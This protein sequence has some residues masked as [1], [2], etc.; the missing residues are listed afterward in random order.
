VPRTR[1]RPT[2]K[3]KMKDEE[4]TKMAREMLEEYPIGLRLTLL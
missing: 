3:E 4:L 1:H 2:T